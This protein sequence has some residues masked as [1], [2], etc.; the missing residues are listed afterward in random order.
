[1][2]NQ[3]GIADQLT[4]GP[5]AAPALV[6]AS[7]WLDSLPPAQPKLTVGSGPNGTVRATWSTG[8][9]EAARVWVLYARQGGQWKFE[10]IP[11]QVTQFDLP[12]TGPN[13]TTDV[14]LSALDQAG[15]ESP[16]ALKAVRN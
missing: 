7:P 15:N 4:S 1:M 9:K 6:P 14:A 2:R 5:Y 13:A 11:P 3:G 12:G 10:L 16:R 8:G